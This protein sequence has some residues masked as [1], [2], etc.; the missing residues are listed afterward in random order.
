MNYTFV[1][2]N[3]ELNAPSFAL[4]GEIWDF[5]FDKKYISTLVYTALCILFIKRQSFNST[6]STAL[7]PH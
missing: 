4:G 6:K 1:E 2:I 7:S 5:G 3:F